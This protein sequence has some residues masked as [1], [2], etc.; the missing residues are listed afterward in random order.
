[1]HQMHLSQIPNGRCTA[2]NTRIRTRKGKRNRTWLQFS[3]PNLNSSAKP[4][5]SLV[6]VSPFTNSKGMTSQS[7]GLG[8]ETRIWMEVEST[9]L[10]HHDLLFLTTAALGITGLLTW[11]TRIRE[12]NPDYLARNTKEVTHSAKRSHCHEEN[13]NR[14]KSDCVIF[15]KSLDIK[16]KMKKITSGRGENIV[17]SSYKHTVHR[18]STPYPAYTIYRFWKEK[19]DSKS[20]SKIFLTFCNFKLRIL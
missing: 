15:K 9:P 1:M 16:I 18:F 17:I 14:E 13:K 6:C 8:K 12:E 11:K 2:K 3:S 7:R 5:S 4:G 10:A 20:P 19:K